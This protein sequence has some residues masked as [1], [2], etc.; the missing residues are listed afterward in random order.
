LIWIEEDKGVLDKN[1]KFSVSLGAETVLAWRFKTGIRAYFP[2]IYE[3]NLRHQLNPRTFKWFDI[4]AN[5]HMGIIFADR[6]SN[7]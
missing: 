4:S 6:F 7:I 3:A 2:F 1:L 5:L